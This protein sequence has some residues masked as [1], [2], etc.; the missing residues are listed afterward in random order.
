[1]KTVFLLFLEPRSVAALAAAAALEAAVS[2]ID[3]IAR[4]VHGF[5]LHTPDEPDSDIASLVVAVN[6][7]SLVAAPRTGNIYY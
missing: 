5:D 6:E 7:I 3:P 4:I 1:M 2:S